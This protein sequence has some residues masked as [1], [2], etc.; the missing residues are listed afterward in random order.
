MKARDGREVARANELRVLKS[1]HKYAWLRTRDIA[2]LHWLPTRRAGQN[3]LELNPVHVGVSAMRMAQRT[4]A[5]L[6]KGRMVIHI[7]APDGSR[8]YGLSEAGARQLAKLGIPAKSGKDHVRRIS[9]SHYHHRRIAN[10]VAILATLQGYRVATETEIAAG[11]WLGGLKG[12]HGKKPDVVVRD[13]K[14]VW[15][16][17]IERSRKNQKEYSKLIDYLLKLWP[18]PMRVPDIVELPS[19]HRLRQVGFVCE[20]AFLDRLKADLL[21]RGWL[22]NQFSKRIVPHRL[23]YVTEAK[24]LLKAS[25]E[26]RRE[27]ST[28]EGN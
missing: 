5:R 22:D 27:N 20:A 3:G 17:E 12:I 9:L 24:F 13:G 19:D 23:L 26:H 7:Q 15:L 11:A 8:I 25:S 1:L 28:V 21:K 14:D 10:E 6:R 16:W 18:V 2:A 4:L